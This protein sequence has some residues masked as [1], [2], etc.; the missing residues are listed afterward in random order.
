VNAYRGDLASLGPHASE[1]VP[2]L[3]FDPP[4][5]ER[6]DEHFL[7][8]S[9][10]PVQVLRVLLEIHD[11]VSHELPRPVKRGV[12]AA[13]HLEKLHAARREKLRRRG[14]ASAA[15][16]LSS[17]RDDGRMLHE[18]KHVVRELSRDPL[19]REPSLQLES[20]GVG[21]EAEV[22]DGEGVAGGSRKQEAGSR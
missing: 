6:A 9:Q 14:A 11:R 16:R 21:E 12:P 3:R 18:K 22:A 10:V 17:E 2:P 20:S 19:S 7:E 4:P 5:A 15:P 1:A 13:L 8:R